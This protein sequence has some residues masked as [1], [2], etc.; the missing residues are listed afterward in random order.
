MVSKQINIAIS[1][2]LLDEQTEVTLDEICRF[3]HVKQ[4]VIIDLV[5]EGIVEPRV[6]DQLPWCFSGDKLS[7]IKRALRLQQD[8][9]LNLPGVAFALDLLDEI[10]ELRKCLKR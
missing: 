1:G 4:T 3:C 8:L 10:E 5:D 9:E 2:V 6:R 7:R